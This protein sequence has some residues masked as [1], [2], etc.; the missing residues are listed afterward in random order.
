MTNTTSLE[1]FSNKANAFEATLRLLSQAKGRQKIFVADNGDLY[2]GGWGSK[3]RETFRSFVGLPSRHHP[4]SVEYRFIDFF[5]NG[6]LTRKMI[7]SQLSHV[8]KIAKQLGLVWGNK[9]QE[10]Q[11]PEL[12]GLLSDYIQAA[13]EGIE[14]DATILNADYTKQFYDHHEEEFPLGN[15]FSCCTPCTPKISWQGPPQTLKLTGRIKPLPVPEK[16]VILDEP[17]DSVV[18]DPIQSVDPFTPIEE[19][20]LETVVIPISVEIPPSENELE[21]SLQEEKT[22][23]EVS[24]AKVEDESKES[25]SWK[26]MGAVGIISLLAGV[27]LGSYIMSLQKPDDIK[28]PCPLPKPC[29]PC[30][31]PIYICRNTT[32][33]AF[34]L[35][36]SGEFPQT[37]LGYLGTASIGVVA[38][39]LIYWKKNDELESLKSQYLID[40]AA[41][42]K[43]LKAKNTELETLKELHREELKTLKKQHQDALDTLKGQHEDVLKTLKEQHQ[44]EI[45]ALNKRH[46]EELQALKGKHQKPPL[47]D[48]QA[49]TTI[50]DPRIKDLED[51]ITSTK[52]QIIAK[53]LQSRQTLLSIFA[54][55]RIKLDPK[56]ETNLT[57]LFAQLQES[58]KESAFL[59]TPTINAIQ[60]FIDE[61]AEQSIEINELVNKDILSAFPEPDSESNE[62]IPDILDQMP[63]GNDE[64]KKILSWLTTIK[65]EYV[66]KWQQLQAQI[67]G[68]ER[69]LHELEKNKKPHTHNGSSVT[70]TESPLLSIDE[71]DFIYLKAEIEKKPI[72][73]QVKIYLYAFDDAL[74]TLKALMTSGKID[75]EN[76]D[77]QK[78]DSYRALGSNAKYPLETQ[79][80]YLKT[81]FES[82]PKDKQKESLLAGFRTAT[83]GLNYLETQVE[84]LKVANQKLLEKIHPLEESTTYYKNAFETAQQAIEEQSKTIQRLGGDLKI[85]TKK[86]GLKRSLSRSMSQRALKDSIGKP[87]NESVAP[88][89]EINLTDDQ[90]AE[91]FKGFYIINCNYFK[92]NP[93]KLEEINDQD[94]S[95]YSSY[96]ATLQFVL[97]DSQSFN[98]S[99][100]LQL[101]QGNEAK[102]QQLSNSSSWL[103]S[104]Q[105]N[106][107]AEPLYKAS[108]SYFQQNP[109]LLENSDE[110]HV[111]SG[112]LAYFTQTD[113][114]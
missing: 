93:S 96:L 114:K 64:N 102:E 65:L 8:M 27:V 54:Q 53:I 17:E 94:L 48:F 57:Q 70:L 49:Q 25:K 59:K 113:E 84:D 90:A 47:E 11:H 40:L 5:Q 66:R 37:L 12:A 56:Q 87:Q 44:R 88:E 3:V 98:S 32:L 30:P 112:F 20:P 21:E 33:P 55:I 101:L 80:K 67:H 110:G 35:K 34:P 97:D 58:E 71:N 28:P 106:R 18:D 2:I 79:L 4:I 24:L 75:S 99:Q 13:Q 92:K 81:G 74:L 60:T 78:M 89:K 50:E 103:T 36:D 95:D 85:P 72:E 51:S 46:Q 109:S 69:K 41:K 111:Y 22:E 9:Q 62:A 31:W 76:I 83:S 86:S 82:L 14:I 63:T 73:E 23:L 26:M 107:F 52:Q 77:I 61:I 38:S 6:I 42:D 108:L 105:V 10:L 45:E 15:G 100:D 19:S 68:L 29:P 1:G 16:P 104:E 39:A 43:E 91:I 7:G